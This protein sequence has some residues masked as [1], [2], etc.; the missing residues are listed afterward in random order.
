MSFSISSVV[1]GMPFERTSYPSA[2]RFE[3]FRAR[4]DYFLSLR[5]GASRMSKGKSTH[6]FSS[7]GLEHVLRATQ[8]FSDG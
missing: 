8:P 6:F 4:E 7:V 3:K 2:V 1:Y 5:K